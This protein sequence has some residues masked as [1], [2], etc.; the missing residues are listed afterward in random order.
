MARDIAA[1]APS[2]K[3]SAGAKWAQ[4]LRLLLPATLALL[5]IGHRVAGALVVRP[6][7]AR[8]G[9]ALGV[10]AVEQLEAAFVLRELPCRGAVGEHE[11]AGAVRILVVDREPDRLLGGVAVGLAAMRQE[12]VRVVGPEPRVQR[13]DPLLRARDHHRA[14]AR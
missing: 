6:A 7:L 9:D 13:L 11:D 3:R 4:A 14:L 10:V 5:P 12:C 1:R 2:D 8:V